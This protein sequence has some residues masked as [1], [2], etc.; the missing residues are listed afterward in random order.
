MSSFEVVHKLFVLDPLF[1]ETVSY[2]LKVRLLLKYIKFYSEL[3]HKDF[4]VVIDFEK[5]TKTL[6]GGL[7]FS[8]L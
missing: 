8:K 4:K 2:D 3:V 5:L 1:I 6:N 7:R